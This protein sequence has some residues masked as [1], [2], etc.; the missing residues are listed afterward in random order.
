MDTPCPETDAAGAG[1]A[2]RLAA[3]V[4]FAAGAHRRAEK[5]AQAA[6]QVH[7]RAAVALAFAEE[8]GARL[9]GRR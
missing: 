7:E 5:M 2:E 8:A 3:I 1:R 9:T 6:R 4:A